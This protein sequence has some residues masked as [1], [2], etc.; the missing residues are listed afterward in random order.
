MN[1]KLKARLKIICP[2][3]FISV[4]GSLLL[5]SYFKISENQESEEKIKLLPE[6]ELVDIY[7]DY[8]INLNNILSGRSTLLVFFHSHCDVTGN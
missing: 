7:S 3:F 4:I 8:P 5:L 6:F 1:P 2:V